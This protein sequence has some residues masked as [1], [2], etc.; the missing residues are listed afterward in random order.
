ML[1]C[2]HDFSHKYNLELSSDPDPVK[3]K[4]KDIFMI[5]KNVSFQKPENLQLAGNPL[6]WV[7]HTTHLGHEFHEDRWTQE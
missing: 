4:L 6:Q 3:T 2:C 1:N 7:S 5:G